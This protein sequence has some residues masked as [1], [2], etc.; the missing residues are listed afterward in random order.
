MRPCASAKPRRA[1]AAQDFG[2]AL[3]APT[4]RG[5]ASRAHGARSGRLPPRFAVSQAARNPNINVRATGRAPPALAAAL[6]R[7]SV[8]NATATPTPRLQAVQ[9]KDPPRTACT[10]VF[11]FRAVKGPL[12]RCAPLTELAPQADPRSGW[13]PCRSGHQ[14][15]WKKRRIASTAA[16]RKRPTL[17]RS[18]TLRSEFACLFGE[19]TGGLRFMNTPGV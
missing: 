18:A 2:Q 6:R 10:S 13:A 4:T 11:L 7:Q 1:P 17:A 5:A 14:L 9:G 15:S 19:G 16:S 3:R 12:R 8:G